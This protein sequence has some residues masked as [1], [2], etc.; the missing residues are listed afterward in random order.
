MLYA[1]STLAFLTVGSSSYEQLSLIL[2]PVSADYLWGITWSP[3][4]GFHILYVFVLC[5]QV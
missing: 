4:Y 2:T 3:A 1:V 5:T